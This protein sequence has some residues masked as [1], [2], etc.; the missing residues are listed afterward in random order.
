MEGEDG[1]RFG[2]GVCSSCRERAAFYHPT[3]QINRADCLG[4]R[5]AYINL[6]P[7][8]LRLEMTW[9][10]NR[11]PRLVQGAD[12]DMSFTLLRSHVATFSLLYT[13]YI[14]HLYPD[15]R[16]SCS[17]RSDP[18]HRDRDVFKTPFARIF[19]DWRNSMMLRREKV[20]D[21]LDL[22][23]P[24]ILSLLHIVPCL[25]GYPTAVSPWPGIGLSSFEVMLPYIQ[26]LE[27]SCRRLHV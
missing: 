9:K 1:A 2:Y 25:F 8:A 20:P 26:W 27:G 14:L 15:C 19:F 7:A 12:L 21:S 13:E 17:A 5:S 10:Y 24:W 4:T 16:P 6:K 23:Q 3:K 22:L 11:G 18:F